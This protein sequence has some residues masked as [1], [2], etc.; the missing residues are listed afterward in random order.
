[1]AAVSEISAR[2]MKKLMAA[3][4]RFGH[5]NFRSIATAL[6]MRMPAKIPFCRACVEAKAT[7]HPKSRVPHPPRSIPPRA[8]YR[9]HFDP[10]G[11]FADRLGDGSYYGILFADAYS[12]LLW[13]DTL[14]ALGA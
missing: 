4:V 14:P 10:F 9:I 13:F 8:G 1:M 6:N 12:S 5:R 3:H 7:R 11:P 2:E